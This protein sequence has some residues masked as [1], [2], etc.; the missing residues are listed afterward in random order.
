MIYEDFELLATDVQTRNEGNTRRVTFK[1]QVP[2]SPAG[3]IIAGI[4]VEYDQREMQEYLSDWESQEMEWKDVIKTGCW[5]SAVLFPMPVRELLVRSLDVMKERRQ[6]LRLR[7]LLDGDLHNIPWEYVLLNRGGGEA[8]VT[9]FLGLMPGVSIVRHQAATLPA[10]NV[11]AQLPMRMIAALASPIGYKALKLSKEQVDITQALA[12]HTSI[13]A[14]F[15]PQATPETLL[16]N[17]EK[18][19]LFHFA[20]HGDMPKE[21]MSAVQ[22]GKY[23]GT[24]VIVLENGNGGPALLEAGQLALRLRQAG[25]RVALLGACRS[26]RRDDVNVWSSVATALLKADLGAVVGMQYT[27]RND[28]AIAFAREFYKALAAG[29]PVDEAVTGGRIAVSGSDVRGWGTPVLYLRAADGVVFPEYAADPALEKKRKQV[30]LSV[31]QQVKILRGRM[32]GIEA[33][34]LSQSATVKQTAGAVEKEAEMVG[35]EA[36]KVKANAKISQEADTVDGTMIGWKSD[37]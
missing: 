6:G 16:G 36:K 10:W 22:P 12:Q 26:G 30:R 8:T 23:E 25:V 17:G 13:E 19:H 2:R 4:P 32:T 15:V 11:K 27:I 1:V 37:R 33:G 9:D 34:T 3:E 20:G 21:V 7:L 14:T 35:I 18:A 5:L 29:L 31:Q 24:G 28:S